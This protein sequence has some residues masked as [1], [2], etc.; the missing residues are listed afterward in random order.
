MPQEM[1]QE[2]E[3]FDQAV[4]QAGQEDE[5][6]IM[7]LAPVGQFSK[8]G[9]DRLVKSVN[10]LVPLFGGEPVASPEG[11]L[12]Q[13][14]EDLTRIL[15]MVLT[16]TETAVSADV[17]DPELVINIDNLVD[18]SGMTMLTGRLEMLAKDKDFKKFLQTPIEEPLVEEEVEEEV[19]DESPEDAEIDDLFEERI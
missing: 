8:S 7:E 14:P 6:M 18:D 13:F 19:S 10:K 4:D 2:M 11:D 1:K 9:V 5:Q 15:A 3:K 16:A 12:Q 17:I